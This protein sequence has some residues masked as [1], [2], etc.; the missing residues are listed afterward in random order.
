MDSRALAKWK[1][2]E[3]RLGHLEEAV[4][5]I[6][7]VLIRRFFRFG[8][9]VVDPRTV[10]PDAV[11]DVLQHLVDRAAAG[12]RPAGTFVRRDGGHGVAHPIEHPPDEP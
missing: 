9:L 12:C 4:D 10:P 7:R 2:E 3:K 11:A 5:S 1:S 8:K 6:E